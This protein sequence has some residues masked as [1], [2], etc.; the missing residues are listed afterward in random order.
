[1]VEKFHLWRQ[2]TEELEQTQA[3][4]KSENDRELREMVETEIEGLQKQVHE[5]EE[6]LTILLLPR[7]PND[8]KNILLEVRG[9]AG[10]DESNLF[11]ADL[12][13]MY[14]RYAERRGW[15]VELVSVNEM[16][17]GGVK[18]AV[19]LIKGEQVYSRMKYESGV[20]RVQRVPITEASGRIHTSTA[21]VA[22]LP[23]AEEVDEIEIRSSDLKIDTFRSGGKGGQNVNKVETAVRITHL[24]TGVVV[25]CQEERSQLQNKEK[26]MHYLRTKLMATLRSEATSEYAANRKSQVGTGDRS[27]RIRTYNFAE[28]RVTDHRIKLTLYKLEAILN[29]DMD[30][31]LDGLLAAEQSE[32]MAA[33]TSQV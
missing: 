17:L 30:E 4:L 3:M 2:A 21:T 24:P 22:V 23:E 20:H 28:N 8:D 7:D 25:A 1:T 13:R 19:L 32:K 12:M 14:S 5:L 11:A 33:L 10:G 29:G 26:A 27:E 16:D 9:G 31:L 18:E 6:R 15:K